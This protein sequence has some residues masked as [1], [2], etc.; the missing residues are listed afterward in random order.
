MKLIEQ[1]R[2]K[3]RFLHYAWDT[4]QCYVGWIERYIHFHRRGVVW[5]HP[6]EMAAKEI[7]EFLTHLAVERHVSA[8]TQNQAFSALLF[9]YQKVLEIEVPMI[10]ALRVRRSQRLPVVLSRGEVKQLLEMHLE[11]TTFST[12]CG[13]RRFPW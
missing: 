3:M 5:R 10:D 7:E 12:I 13:S 11:T 1:V 8:S 9:L 4:E 6:N 2:A